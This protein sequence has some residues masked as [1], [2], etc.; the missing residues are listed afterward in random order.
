MRVGLYGQTLSVDKKIYAEQLLT[1]FKNNG[2]VVV[3]EKKFH[4]LL[5][6]LDLISNDVE[7]FEEEDDLKNNISLMF[8][9]GGDGTI[10]RVLSFIKN[11]EIPIVGINLGRLGF[12]ATIPKE[13]IKLNVEN[14]I[15]GKYNILDRQ[16]LKLTTSEKVEN[17]PYNYALNEIAISRKETT[18]M[19][20]I[21]AYLDNEYLNSYWAD[22][23]IIA[24]PTGSTGYSLSC[25]GPIIMPESSNMV[26]TPIAPH[27]LYA[28]PFVIPDET[29]INLN[30][31]GRAENYL[32]S[33]DSRLITIP[34]HI[35]LSIKKSN[36]SIKMV[37]LEDQRF[38]KT[39][40][41]KMFWGEDYRN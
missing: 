10:L 33:L 9:L 39:L 27:N 17:M 7:F 14:I 13:D 11:S 20:T 21:D 22:G 26:L 1:T 32:V 35:K 8:T 18:S 2:I 12:M 41:K 25:G 40:R 28:R 23:L 29:K 16:L 15:K 6:N 4:E 37:Q 38:L 5:A 30:V 36:F 34:H 19:I 3:I 24:T 31:S